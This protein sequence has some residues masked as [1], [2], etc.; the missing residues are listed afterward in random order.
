MG[1][2]TDTMHFF[3][4]GKLVIDQGLLGSTFA[5]HYKGLP[6]PKGLIFCRHTVKTRIADW[7]LT[8]PCPRNASLRQGTPMSSAYNDFFLYENYKFGLKLVSG[9]PTFFF[10]GS[11]G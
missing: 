5:G 2:T 11:N 3:P 4:N 6:W 8:N 1:D 7:G 9:K 10:G